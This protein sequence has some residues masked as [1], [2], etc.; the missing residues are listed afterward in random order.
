[1]KKYVSI[2]KK[3][4]IVL[5]ACLLT[6]IAEAKKTSIN[7]AVNNEITIPQDDNLTN[8]LFESN[9][10][11][12][13]IAQSFNSESKISP[14]QIGHTNVHANYRTSHT[15]V[16]SDYAVNNRHSNSHSNTPSHHVNDHS[17]S[18]I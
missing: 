18:K 13:R 4:G 1:M 12:D 7:D 6:S 10:I 5:P 11:K 2:A 14:Y 15:D 17:N 3:L 8:S 9:P 16:H